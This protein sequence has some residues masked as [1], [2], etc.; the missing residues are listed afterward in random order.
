MGCDCCSCENSKHCFVDAAV[1]DVAL[2]VSMLRLLRMFV[3][4][5]GMVC[6]NDMDCHGKRLRLL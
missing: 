6:L 2:V 4:I 3:E 1:A 5:E